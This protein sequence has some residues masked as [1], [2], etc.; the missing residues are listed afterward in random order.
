MFVEAGVNT[1]VWSSHHLFSKFFNFF[2]GSGCSPF[3]TTEI[4][5]QCLLKKLSSTVNVRARG[6]GAFLCYVIAAMLEGKNNTFSLLW[7]I[8]YIFMQ[9][10]FIVSAP[11]VKTLC[12]CWHHKK[13]KKCMT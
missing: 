4:E 11:A 3:E 1:D 6:C 10:C 7:E 13:V 9:N 12:S 5:Q 8:R 2:D